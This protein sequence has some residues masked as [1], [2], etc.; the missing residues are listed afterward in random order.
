MPGVVD[1][2]LAAFPGFFL[3]RMGPPFLRQLYAGFLEVEHGVLLVAC[4]ERN[5]TR[6]LGFVAGT[7]QPEAFF[8]RLLLRRGI[9]FALASV[10]PLIRQPAWVG[11]KLWSALF[12]RG[13][14]L[15][16]VPDAALLSS[17]GVHP[18]AQR[19]GLGRHLVRAF[20]QHA[21]SRNVDAIYLTTDQ[22]GNASANDF[23][24]T[25]G[26]ELAGTVARPGGRVLNRYLLGTK[27]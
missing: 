26:F 10:R 17:L 14:T 13:E 24:R 9:G 19:R 7:L 23:Y 20:L 5:P 21:Q 3:S 27:P 6:M 22:M 18:Q 11:R 2:H 8:G 16:E 4:D 1:T 15:P 12:Y 25:C